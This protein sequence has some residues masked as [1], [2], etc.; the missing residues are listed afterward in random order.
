MPNLEIQHVSI[1]L[2]P[3]HQRLRRLERRRARSIGSSRASPIRDLKSGVRSFG[4]ASDR[5]E[6]ASSIRLFGV[7]GC[8]VRN[9][10]DLYSLGWRTSL[11][12]STGC[13]TENDAKRDV[14]VFHGPGEDR[15]QNVCNLPESAG[16]ARLASARAHRREMTRCERRGRLQR[17]RSPALADRPS[18]SSSNTGGH[19]NPEPIHSRS[20]EYRTGPRHWAFWLLR[21]SLARRCTTPIRPVGHSVPVSSRLWLRQTDPH[22]RLALRIPIPLRLAGD[23]DTRRYAR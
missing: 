15:G 21:D 22:C 4:D 12:K 17:P 13:K 8:P 19:T 18:D 6:I 11:P 14:N 16:A 5:R 20:R 3:Q 1:A 23:R 10:G 2:E 9:A 7:D